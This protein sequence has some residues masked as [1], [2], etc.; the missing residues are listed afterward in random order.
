MGES[1]KTGGFDKNPISTK[2]ETVKKIG[3]SQTRT[4]SS[5][6]FLDEKARIV[7]SDWAQHHFTEKSNMNRFQA[8]RQKMLDQISI[9]DSVLGA[10]TTTAFNETN[11]MTDM[12]EVKV[13]S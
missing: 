1:V 7:I 3:L 8:L 10:D 4:I 11:D 5:H 12:V 9:I 2:I 6:Y 13:A